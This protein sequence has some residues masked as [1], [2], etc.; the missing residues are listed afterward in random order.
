MINP[1]KN[2][3]CYMLSKQYVKVKIKKSINWNIF[4]KVFSD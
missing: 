3:S 4:I 1:F 2:I